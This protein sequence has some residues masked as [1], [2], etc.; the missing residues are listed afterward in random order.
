MFISHVK[1][2][3]PSFDSLVVK[4]LE[5]PYKSELSKNREL[6]WI[7]KPLTKQSYLARTDLFVMYRNQDEL[8]FKWLL[9]LKF[10]IQDNELRTKASKEVKPRG[11]M[12]LALLEL[13]IHLHPWLSDRYRNYADLFAECKRDMDMHVAIHCY[14]CDEQSSGSKKADTARERQIIDQLKCGENPYDCR[15]MPAMSRLFDVAINYG[16]HDRDK[17]KKPF[18]TQWHAYLKSY[19]SWVERL[20]TIGKSTFVFNDSLY[21]QSGKGKQKTKVILKRML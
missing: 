1:I 10:H 20:D 13:C 3:I 2:A 11:E 8:A 18:S 14:N 21:E 15:L 12:L 6:I 5:D 7:T 19:K 4:D 17:P 9:K 16:Y